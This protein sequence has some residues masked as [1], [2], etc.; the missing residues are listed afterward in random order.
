M[1]SII[2]IDDEEFITA[3]LS[4]YITKH[5]PSYLVKGT[6]TDAERALVFLQEN[7][8][9]V[10]ITDILMSNMNGLELIKRVRKLLPEV[11]ILIISG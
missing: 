10:I 11:T 6:F 8:V 2:I 3:S 9:D 4:K 7:P 1:Y 5:H